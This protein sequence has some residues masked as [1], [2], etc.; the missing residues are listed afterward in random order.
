M[1]P[2]QGYLIR[3]SF[4]GDTRHYVYRMHLVRS[5]RC[6]P[7][8]MFVGGRDER[9]WSRSRCSIFNPSPPGAH[10][11]AP[12]QTTMLET[13]SYDCEPNATQTLPRQGPRTCP[14]YDRGMEVVERRTRRRR[15]CRAHRRI[16]A[17][18]RRTE[19]QFRS[20]DNVQS[21]ARVVGPRRGSCPRPHAGRAAKAA[22]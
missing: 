9:N 22:R 17:A 2:H 7:V 15:Q 6:R 13:P 20:R 19:Q 16:R 3:S 8:L 4:Q 1:L 12:A 14:S 5:T 10:S 11:K 18:C 21:S